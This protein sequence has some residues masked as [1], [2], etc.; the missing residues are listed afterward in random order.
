[1]K[2]YETVKTLNE[3]TVTRIKSSVFYWLAIILFPLGIYLISKEILFGGVF[4]SL[5]LVPCLIFYPPIR[6]LFGGK[7]S[8]AAVVTTVVV[9]EILKAEIHKAIKKRKKR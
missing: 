4:L 9:E 3:N 1:M 6:F 5:F 8:V 2:I 7:D